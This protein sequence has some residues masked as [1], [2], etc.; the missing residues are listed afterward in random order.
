MKSAEVIAENTALK[1]EVKSLKSQLQLAEARLAILSAKTFHTKSEKHPNQP[2]LP[3][4]FN[5]AEVIVDQNSAVEETTISKQIRKTR[6]SRTETQTPDHLPRVDVHHKALITDCPCCQSELKETKPEIQEQLACLPTK[7]YVVRHHYQRFTCDCDQ[8][9]PITAQRPPRALPKSGIHAVALSTWIEQ[10]YEY[11]LPLYRLERMAKAAGVDISRTT[12]ASSIIK[13]SQ[14]LFQPLINLFND[15][16]LAYDV[17]WMDET[18]VQVIKEPGRAPESKSQ[19]W[20][21]RGG[22]PGQESIILDYSPSR[23][24][25]TCKGLLPEF[26]GFLISDAYSAYMKLG[27]TDH[28]TNVLCS[29]HAR[30]KFKEAYDTLDKVSRPGSIADQALKRYGALYTLEKK[31]THTDPVHRYKIR[32]EKAKPLWDAFIEWLQKMQQQGVA[33]PKT[34]QAIDYCLKHKEGLQTYLSDG[35]LPISNILAEHVAKHIAVSR[36][37]FLFSDTPSGATA[38]AHC[39]SVIQTAKLHGHHVHKYLAVLVSEL[40]AAQT[41]EEFE[42]YLPW[43]ITLQEIAKRYSELPLI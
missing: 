33:H 17:V 13:V 40:P 15:S 8:Q 32:Q 30:R 35:R 5:E 26:K 27:T 10:K 21:R 19:F 34:T 2:E 1:S 6:K 41:P 28:V 38:S 7:F 39:F 16:V 14:N 22:P 24:F 23:S 3:F 25:E 20:I 18:R 43:N 9:P 29:D 4:E 42:V 37:N 36:K 31:M 12:I 11:A